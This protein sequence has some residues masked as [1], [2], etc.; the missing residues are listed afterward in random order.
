MLQRLLRLP[1][2]ACERRTVLGR[3]PGLPDLP[4]SEL[5]NELEQAAQRTRGETARSLGAAREQYVADQLG[6]TVTADENGV[7]MRGG[8][9]RLEWAVNKWRTWATWQHRNR[10]PYG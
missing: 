9:V 8:L 2:R 6:G 7:G 5:A 10:T 1:R 3:C 4:G